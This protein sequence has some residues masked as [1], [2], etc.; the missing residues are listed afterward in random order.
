MP[1]PV[2]Q[3][4]NAVAIPAAVPSNSGSSI[5]GHASSPLMQQKQPEQ[6]VMLGGVTNKVAA[7]ENKLAA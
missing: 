2:A 3:N 6:E 4:Q 7:A 5:Q 1:K